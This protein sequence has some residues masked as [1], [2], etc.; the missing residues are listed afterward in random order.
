MGALCK[1]S[2]DWAPLAGRI[3]L[4]FVFLQSAFDKLLHYDKTLALM[5]ARAVPE[6]AILLP[7]AMAV[8]FI[9]GTMLLVGWKA[10]WGALA[11][12]A[13][14]IAATW[15]FHAFWTFPEPLQ[16]NQ[17]HHFV[18]NLGVIG[19]LFLLLGMGSGAMSVDGGE[20]C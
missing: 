19:A 8:L 4:S 1:L 16:L 2:K 14:M 17:F 18:K 15:Y 7:I 12:I 9:G 13:F 20:G 6:P 10:R 11:L 5:S 3:L